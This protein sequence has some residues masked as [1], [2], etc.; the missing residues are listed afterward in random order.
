MRTV[1]A[2][3]LMAR[4]RNTRISFYVGV[5]FTY[6]DFLFFERFTP[7]VNGVTT[8]VCWGTNVLRTL[9]LRKNTW[10]K[11]HDSTSEH[12][13]GDGSRVARSRQNDR[14]KRIDRE[15]NIALSNEGCIPGAMERS[16]GIVSV[17]NG[18]S[19]SNSIR[20]V[21]AHNFI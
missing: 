13:S 1:G 15:G 6:G 7:P 9:G 21:T 5:T 10:N 14:Y 17:A 11:E 20:A 18:N 2:T 19:R 8:G 3:V 16:E 12:G 4:M